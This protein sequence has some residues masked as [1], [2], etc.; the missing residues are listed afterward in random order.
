[1]Y[2]NF[3]QTYDHFVN[4]KSRLNYELPFIEATLNRLNISPSR[5]GR[6]LDTACGTGWHAIAL[7]Q[8]GWATT[9]T[10]FASGMIEQAEKNALQEQV[11]V[12]FLQ[13]GFGEIKPGLTSLYQPGEPPGFD[14]VLCLGN[15]LPH[16]LNTASLQVALNDFAACLRPGGLVFI[17]NRNFDLVM[18]NRQ[19][20]ME[21]QS[22]QTEDQEWLFLRF[23][24]FL[25]D[26]LINFHVISLTRKKSSPWQMEIHTTQLHPL[27]QK[28]LSHLLQVAGFEQIELYGD[29]QGAPF[30][31]GHSGNLIAVAHLSD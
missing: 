12:P 29:M 20:W 2:D 13:A 1:M 5:P 17:Q 25:P 18:Q 4:W 21:P 22:Q 8:R 23:Y 10:D 14:A 26:G 9:G 19:R 15:S 30:N 31:P 27:L 11:E 7:A 3:S 28:E 24:D 16:L 6:I